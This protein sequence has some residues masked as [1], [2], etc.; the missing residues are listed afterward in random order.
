MTE[1]E[2]ARLFEEYRA[3][4]RAIEKE[5][6]GC[7]HRSD[8]WSSGGS[9][10]HG[11]IGGRKCPASS[12]HLRRRELLKRCLELYTSSSGLSGSPA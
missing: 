10:T 4:A 8:R 12:Y 3:L 1:A 7:L 6:P 5:H 2:A 11:L 9:Y